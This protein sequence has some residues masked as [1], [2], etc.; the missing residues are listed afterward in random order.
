MRVRLVRRERGMH[1]NEKSDSGCGW[2]FC[3]MDTRV[4]RLEPIPLSRHV[5][6]TA[7]VAPHEITDERANRT[8]NA[9]VC[10]SM[11]EQPSNRRTKCKAGHRANGS[12]RFEGVQRTLLTWQHQFRVEVQPCRSF[13][14]SMY[15]TEA[16]HIHTRTHTHTHVR[17]ST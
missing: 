13:A 7:A 17:T 12:A 1:S 4:G 3:F 16:M 10:V 14:T 8:A 5:V 11:R 15:D 2:M 6:A 9:V